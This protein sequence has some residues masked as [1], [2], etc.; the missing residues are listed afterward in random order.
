MTL[1]RLQAIEAMS[2][3]EIPQDKEAKLICQD[4]W[5]SIAVTVITILGVVVY[6]YRA[7]SKITFF[8]GYLYDNV[9]TI[10]VFLSHDCYHVPV[11]LRDINGVLH[12]FFNWTA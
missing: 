5:V 12:T 8:K 10:Y 2:A 9:C 1:Q 6:L 7:C 3:F 4:P 11:K